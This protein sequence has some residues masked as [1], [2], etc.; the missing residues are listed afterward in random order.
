MTLNV[1]YTKL[2]SDLKNIETTYRGFVITELSMPN[3]E[4]NSKGI[5]NNSIYVDASNSNQSIKLLINLAVLEEAYKDGYTI[6]ESVSVDVTIDTITVDS[7]GT[8]LIKISKIAESGI[9]E[10][11]LFIRNLT[12]YCK[13]N[14]LFDRPKRSYP[15]LVKRVALISTINTNTL[16][17]IVSNLDYTLETSSFK[18]QNTSNAIAEQIKLCNNEDYDLL[19]LYRG[20]HEDKS[21]NIYSDI[22]VLN[23][24]HESNIHI[25]V[26]LGHEVDI[27]FVYRIADS[28]YSTPTNFAQVINSHNQNV[29]NIFNGIVLNIKV[30]IEN[31]KNKIQNDLYNIKIDNIHHITNKLNSNVKLCMEKIYNHLNKA[32]HSYE[33]E[34]ENNYSSIKAK[35]EFIISNISQDLKNTDNRINTL[36]NEIILKSDQKKNSKIKLILTV[37]LAIA[38]IIILYLLFRQ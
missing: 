12:A 2:K 33:L 3:F 4:R 27:P 24:I 38:T 29:K 10:Q 36:V 6:N 14:K 19:L 1:F 11:E 8:V 9:S 32:M 34:I 22:P 7:R 37:T 23:A 17:D 31:L 35:Q 20:G 28:T 13:E 30:G 18:V 26:A 5:Y 21:M 16:D 25:G 15:T